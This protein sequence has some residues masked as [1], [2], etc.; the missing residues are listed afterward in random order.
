MGALVV[1]LTALRARM[2]V[3]EAYVLAGQ[4]SKRISVQSGFCQHSLL[5]ANRSTSTMNY[6]GKNT[7]LEFYLRSRQRVERTCMYH[8]QQRTA[9]RTAVA[10]QLRTF[11]SDRRPTA[12]RND[13]VVSVPVRVYRKNLSLVGELLAQSPMPVLSRNASCVFRILKGMSHSSLN[14]DYTTMCLLSVL[15]LGRIAPLCRLEEVVHRMLQS[16]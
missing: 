10:L 7:L 16:S 2:C 13:G 3:F 15:R 14:S 1:R 8:I 12:R 11:L 5:Q 4:T 9:C 6:L